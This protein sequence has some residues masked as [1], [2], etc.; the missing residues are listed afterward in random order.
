MEGNVAD[1]FLVMSSDFF[2]LVF[3]LIK[4]TTMQRVNLCLFSPLDSARS[5]VLLQLTTL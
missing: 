4:Q 1:S 3:V 2:K 5:S